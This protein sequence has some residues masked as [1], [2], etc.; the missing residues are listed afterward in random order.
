MNEKPIR[1]QRNRSRGWRRPEGALYVGRPTK[2]GNPCLVG[3]PIGYKVDGVWHS[4]ATTAADAVAW[5]REML[6]PD[7]AMAEDARRELRGKDL[8]CW[9][10]LD[11]PCHADILLEIANG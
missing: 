11:Q 5:Y 3:Q 10:R 2:W 8:C 1:I 7:S 4:R 6:S 9:C